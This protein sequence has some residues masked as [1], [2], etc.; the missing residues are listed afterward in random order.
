MTR[1]V[2]SVCFFALVVPSSPVRAD[3]VAPELTT[4]L[5]K[6]AAFRP[7]G[8]DFGWR[9]IPWNDD[10]TAAL[11]EAR[12]EKRPLLVWLAGGRDRDGTPLERC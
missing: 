1:I 5:K 8:S 4:L 6:A 9:E 7:G 3:D 12:D 2:S 10:P 11:K